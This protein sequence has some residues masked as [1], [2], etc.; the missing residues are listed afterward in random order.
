[1]N[2]QNYKGWNC[3]FIEADCRTTIGTRTRFFTFASEE[4]FRSFVSRCNLEDMADFEHSM[5]AWAR[6][7]NYANLTDEQYQKLKR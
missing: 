5:R 3:H 6:G 7:S 4:A 1:M 2:F